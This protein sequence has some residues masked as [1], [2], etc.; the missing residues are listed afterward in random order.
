MLKAR[1]QE[2]GYSLIELVIAVGLL[3]LIM[4]YIASTFTLQY[5]TYSVVDQVSETQNNTLAV[6]ALIERDIRNAGYMVP[7]AAAACGAD[8]TSDADTLYLSD[9]SAILPID[10]L[11]TNLRSDVMSADVQGSPSNA[12][13]IW[14][15]GVDDIV[16]DGNATYDTD[17]NGTNDSD[18]QVGAGV[19]VIDIDDTGRGIACGV[20]SSVD[21]ASNTLIF[22][23]TTTT[24]TGAMGVPG[25]LRLIPA[26]VYQVVTP[27][28]AA[29]P[30][31]QRNSQT[32]ARDT[33]DL[34]VAWFFDDD[35]DGV[36]DTLEYRAS[37]L[38]IATA[39]GSVA[40]APV[41]DTTFDT[42][43]V[44]GE[45]LREIRFNIVTR[46][47]SDD[48]RNPSNAGTGQATE[49][50]AT[51]IPG[52]DGRRRRIYSATVRLRNTS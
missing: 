15:M 12:G 4:S 40:I 31:I 10:Q 14:T 41:P 3:G 20:I 37:A 11:P 46:T 17:G 36:V 16:L 1:R 48:P 34:Q 25:S 28:G 35:D 30:E 7:T 42:S 19:I 38:N 24:L 39:G 9:A 33:E 52:T 50:R 29:Q 51:N 6:A 43:T 13:S 32:L 45:L 2:R 18:F 44:D 8:S 49:N 21:I 27:G 47:R 22:D 5:Q 26:N 23:L